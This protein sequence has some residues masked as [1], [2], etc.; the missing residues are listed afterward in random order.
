VSSYNAASCKEM[1]PVSLVENADSK[2]YR[3]ITE[4]HSGSLIEPEKQSLSCEIAVQ[5]LLLIWK[6]Q[7]CL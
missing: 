5:H 6:W 3:S 2:N 7:R 4:C 1:L